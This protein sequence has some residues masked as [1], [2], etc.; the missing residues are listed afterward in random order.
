MTE[1][2]SDNAD[3][4]ETLSFDELSSR[5]RG[6]AALVE[7]YQVM[8]SQTWRQVSSILSSIPLGLAVVDGESL[9]E[10][11]NIQ[12]RK[13]FEYDS[14]D[15]YAQPISVL[16]PELDNLHAETEPRKL[17]GR[18]KAGQTFPCEVSINEI[19]FD[20]GKRFCVH[21]K[22]ISEKQKMIEYK[23][24]L[25]SMVSH[26]L[27][28]PLTTMRSVLSS[29]E[30][31]TYGELNTDGSEAIKWALV[32]SDYMNSVLANI[33]DAERIDASGMSIEPI[34][35]STGKVVSDAMQLCRLYADEL[36]V[37]IEGDFRNDIFFADEARLVRV[38]VNLLANAIKFSPSGSAVRVE[39][40]LD[41]LAVVFRV[42][43]KGPGI[44][45]DMQTILF[46]RFQQINRSSRDSKAGFGLGLSI[47]RDFAQLHGGTIS[48]KSQPGLGST[49]EVSIPYRECS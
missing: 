26:D 44:P 1:S 19:E 36:G 37:V 27:R 11:T 42:I 28:T 29:I 41:G 5:Y 35:T 34:E 12:L 8:Q 15:L 45:E 17:I 22:D 31:G 43:D 46:D 2:K 49:F 13:L 30:N 20:G 48:V 23:M 7:Q 16:F 32:S 47:S 10:A 4:I 14:A 25:A 33:L 40:G 3:N 39:A 21:V 24:N 6:L 38:L 18:I 9:I